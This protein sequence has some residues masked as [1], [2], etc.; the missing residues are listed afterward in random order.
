MRQLQISI[1]NLKQ[2]GDLCFTLCPR[3]AGHDNRAYR[4]TLDINGSEITLK[5][6]VWSGS[7]TTCN[8]VGS[9]AISPALG[10]WFNLRIEYEDTDSGAQTRVYINGS[11]VYTTNKVYSKQLNL[12]NNNIALMVVFMKGLVT[13]V[14]FDDTQLITVDKF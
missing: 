9:V 5:E 3:N 4:I 2:S 8:T 10:S 11:K 14:K 12:D 7:G 6:E 13:T 1:S